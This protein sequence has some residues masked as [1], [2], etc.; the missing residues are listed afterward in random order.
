[1][2]KKQK[3]FDPGRREL[4]KQGAAV[5]IS[6]TTLAAFSQEELEA[7]REWEHTADVI[8]V[9]SGAAGLPAAIAA[10]DAGASVI[11][12][13][14][15]FDVG[16]RQ[17]LNGG[18]VLLGGGTSVQ[19]KFGVEDSA[20]QVYLDYTNPDQPMARYNDRELARAFADNSAATFEF[21]VANGVKFFDRRPGIGTQS[22]WGGAS[23]RRMHSVGRFSDDLRETIGGANG[24]GLARP[25]E[26]SARAKGVTF[27]LQHKMTA[28]V[29]E[30]PASVR[31]LG[32][33]A[34]H[35]GKAVNIRA[36]KGVIVA[37]GG[38]QG[39]V[40][41]RRIFD[42][43]LTDEG[44]QVWG[45]PYAGQTGD[46]QRAVL[47][48]GATF[49][50]TANQTQ[51]RNIVF[52]KPNR[53]GT[54]YAFGFPSGSPV[55]HLA[56]AEGLL[57]RNWE[58]LILVNQVGQRFWNEE[59]PNSLASGT[60]S[61]YGYL[62]AAVGSVVTD[63][64]GTMERVGGPS[65]AIFDTD[66]LEREGWDPNPP[67]VDPEGYFF[68][69]DTLAELARNIK[70]PHQT[71][72]MSGATLQDTVGRYNSFVVVGEDADFGKTV[73]H[74]IQTPPFYAAWAT[75]GLHDSL[76]GLRI[77]G[78]VQ[79]VDSTGQVIPGLYA[80]GECAGGLGMHGQ[81]RCMVFGR[82]AGTNAAAEEA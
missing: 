34:T 26:A 76:T 78:K 35:E 82:V 31:V 17:M 63:G 79:V 58:D 62:A 7:Q 51:E 12:V 61:A 15:N 48:I 43:R 40:N 69:A 50:G 77:N 6:A 33:V 25:L 59:D 47:Q 44:Y 30:G 14:A 4:L 22:F 46:G 73:G 32:A 65:W 36:R 8:V 19:K 55:F 45:E 10:A 1:M 24:S 71:V 2:N 57:V 81:A 16:G 21:L 28:I 11:V 52:M 9:G 27:L 23:V 60:E 13:E 49:W 70:N 42:P 72:A 67:H 75:P 29:R 80:A 56:R 3:T 38:H 5:G 54:R 18:Q 39:D 74:Q 53:I 20:D 41:F 66:A 64:A 68:K 37:T